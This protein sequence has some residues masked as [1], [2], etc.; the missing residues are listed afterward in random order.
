MPRIEDWYINTVI[1]LYPSAEQANKGEAAGGSGFLVLYPSEQH[2]DIGYLYGVT[3]SHVIRECN[4]PVIR[5]NTQRGDKDVRT[6]TADDWI[7]HTDGD[8]LA[9]THIG[10]IDRNIYKIGYVP[11]TKFLTKELSAEY[12]IGAGDDVFMAGRFI[13]HEGKQRNMPIVRFGNISMMPLEP[14][15]D[16]RG[17]KQECYLVEMRS[18]AGFSGS[19]VFVYI[20]SFT[21]R[22]KDIIANGVINP[23]MNL[24]MRGP[25]LLGVDFADLPFREKVFQVVHFD[26]QSIE[27]PADYVVH[28]NSGQAAVIPAWRLLDFIQNDERF[29]MA[30]KEGDKRHEQTKVKSPLRPNTLKSDKEPELTHAD[31]EEALRRTSRKTSEPES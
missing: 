29:V 8:D 14:I 22:P 21:L 27:S 31:F 16:F 7:D 26:E 17:R 30:R 11:I 1:Y 25:W 5:L 2:N 28:S 23:H 24:A 6:L 20:P 9:V 4:S 13:N 18:L 3:N 15:T 10:G 12:D 19:P